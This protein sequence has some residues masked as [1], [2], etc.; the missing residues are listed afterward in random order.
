MYRGMDMY[1]PRDPATKAE[2][3]ATIQAVTPEYFRAMRL[4][5]IEG[6]TFQSSDD[7]GAL[8]AIV[9]NRTFAARYL[10]ERPLGQRLNLGMANVPESEVI[11]VVEDMRLGST[12]SE[13]STFGGVLDPPMGQIFI[14]H[15]QWPFPIED[16]IVVVRSLDD[17]SA[18]AAAARAIVR[19]EDPTL[20]IDSILTMEDRVAASLAGPRSYAV[21]LIGF[22]LCALVIAGVGLFGV[23]SYVTSQ[24][25]REIGLR[26]A[27][28]ARRADVLVLVGK[29]AVTITCAGL[30]V[31]LVAAFFL[32]QMLS[33]LLYGISTRDAMSFTVVPLVLIV[34]SIAACAAPAW[35]AT[36]IDPLVALRSE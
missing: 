35:R 10:G 34:V 9:V 29:Q 25:T 5:P 2:V 17:P 19:A 23:L 22:S 12:S 3:Q 20:P 27:L 31:G 4:R 28:G 32:S 8:S 30:A 13:P 14:L 26:S 11:G 7:S 18:L 33:T 6:R 15:R 16:L 1:L 36:R 21:F 24:R